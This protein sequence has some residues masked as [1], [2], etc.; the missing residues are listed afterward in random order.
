M[1]IIS[2]RADRIISEDCSFELIEFSV[3]YLS[4]EKT[5]GISCENKP[6][7]YKGYRLA[8]HTYKSIIPSN[9]E[10]KKCKIHVS[11]TLLNKYFSWK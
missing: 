2:L 11:R 4:K 6:N 7:L 5:R 3:W 10:Q 9:I 8:S 1:V